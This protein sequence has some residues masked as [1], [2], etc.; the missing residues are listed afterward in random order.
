MREGSQ[1]ADAV[2]LTE[3]EIIQKLRAKIPIEGDNWTY[4][5]KLKVLP[6]H[7]VDPHVHVGWTATLHVPD[8]DETV[9]VHLIVG[10]SVWWPSPGEV[11]LIPPGVVH[12]VPKWGGDFPRESFALTVNEGDNRQV[13]KEVVR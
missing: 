10:D 6:G 11:I 9:L 12:S 8:K 4:L 7:S 5:W 3:H 13:V 2:P 1:P